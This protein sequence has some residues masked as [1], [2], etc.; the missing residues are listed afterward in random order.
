MKWESFENTAVNI[1]DNSWFITPISPLSLI[2]WI[3]KMF[4][5]LVLHLSS[6]DCCHFIRKF[7]VSDYLFKQR[8]KQRVQNEPETQWILDSHPRLIGRSSNT[9]PL[10]IQSNH[11]SVYNSLVSRI[12][13]AG[14]G[15]RESANRTWNPETDPTACRTCSSELRNCAF[16]NIIVIQ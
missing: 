14:I 6:S 8:F 7:V 15:L 11:V 10:V 9:A 16:R 3:Y 1:Y 4:W 5:E 13:Y 12:C 2:Y